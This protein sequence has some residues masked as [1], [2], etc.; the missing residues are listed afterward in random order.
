MEFE[1]RFEAFRRAVMLEGRAFGLKTLDEA[2][3]KFGSNIEAYDLIGYIPAFEKPGITV[4]LKEET[5]RKSGLFGETNRVLVEV[6]DGFLNSWMEIELFRREDG[7]IEPRWRLDRDRLIK[8]WEKAGY[9]QK[10]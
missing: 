9:P 1:V 6:K 8:D 4:Q 2:R 5:A 3:Y 7:K 10:W